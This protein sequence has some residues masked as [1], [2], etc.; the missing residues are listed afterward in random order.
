MGSEEKSMNKKMWLS[1]SLPALG[2][3]GLAAIGR[4]AHR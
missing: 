4:G 1:Q 3:F 2:M